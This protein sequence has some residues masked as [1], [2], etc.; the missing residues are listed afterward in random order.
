M[1]LRFREEVHFSVIVIFEYAPLLKRSTFQWKFSVLFLI[2][3]TITK[4]RIV[5]F[6]SYNCVPIA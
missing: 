2:C 3:V 5:A 4:T 6:H 1:A